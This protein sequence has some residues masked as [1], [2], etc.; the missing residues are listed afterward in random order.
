MHVA[1][2]S[3]KMHSMMVALG[4]TLL[5]DAAV[6]AQ[7]KRLALHEEHSLEEIENQ[8]PVSG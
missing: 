3:R 8:T 6:D 2:M 7:D 4:A 5:P 1:E